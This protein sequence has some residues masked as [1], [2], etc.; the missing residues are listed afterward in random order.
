L[1]FLPKSYFTN[2]NTFYELSSLLLIFRVKTRLTARESSAQS[3][4]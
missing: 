2:F 3:L 1:S 4:A